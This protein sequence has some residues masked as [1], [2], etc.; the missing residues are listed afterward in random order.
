MVHCLRIRNYRHES[1]DRCTALGLGFNRE[2]PVQDFQPLIHANETE[3]PACFCCP[4]I[5]AGSEVA[6]RKM[7]L[8]RRTPRSHFELPYTA[9]FC[10]IVEGFLQHSEKTERNVG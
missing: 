5:K 9:M 7:N 1:M 6:N 2:R 8:I 4:L 10:R 3:P